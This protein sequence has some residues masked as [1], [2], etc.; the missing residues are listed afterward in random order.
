MAAAEAEARKNNWF[1][2]I[3]IVDSGGHLVMLQRLDNTRYD[4]LEA[5]QEKDRSAAAFRRPIKDF[6]NLIA[7]GRVHLHLLSLNGDAG[8]LQGAVPVIVD[9]EVIGCHRY[10]ERCFLA[11][12]P[13]F[14]GRGQRPDQLVGPAKCP[15]PA[16]TLGFDA[17][18]TPWDPREFRIQGSET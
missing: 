9:G 8:V 16:W 6:Q 18:F 12:R 17:K 15:Q 7:H 13:G 2:A 14:P 4:S 3:V 5:A 1:M 10:L 11:G